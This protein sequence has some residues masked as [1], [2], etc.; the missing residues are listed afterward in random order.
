MTYL[1]NV[2]SHYS[3]SPIWYSPRPYS[4]ILSFKHDYSTIMFKPLCILKYLVWCCPPENEKEHPIS[5]N[6][7]WER[8]LKQS[9]SIG[10]SEYRKGIPTEKHF[11]FHTPGLFS[12]ILL[13]LKETKEHWLTMGIAPYPRHCFGNIWGWF[14]ASWM[15]GKCCVGKVR[16]AWCFEIKETVQ[17][18]IVE[19]TVLHWA[20][21]WNVLHISANAKT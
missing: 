4:T 21:P 5:T 7:R 10:P 19:R 11:W 2:K 15:I 1:F 9:E 17:F 16:D 20:Q 14:L 3:P 6:R 13:C 12:L 18:H 8:E